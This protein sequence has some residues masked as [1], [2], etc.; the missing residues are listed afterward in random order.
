MSLLE[1]GVNKMRKGLFICI[2]CQPEK[3]YQTSFSC[4][5]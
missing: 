5:L 1:F 3:V 4:A 2:V